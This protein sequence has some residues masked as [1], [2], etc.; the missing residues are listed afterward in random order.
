MYNLKKVRESKGLSQTQLAARS[1]VP[2]RIVRAYEAESATAH[3]DINKGEALRVWQLARALGVD[4]EAILE[5]TAPI[6]LI[7]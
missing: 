6:D 7:D 1:G 5:P 2:V 3:K 4:V